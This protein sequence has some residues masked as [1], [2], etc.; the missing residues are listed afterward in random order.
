MYLLI[1]YIL[2]EVSKINES[3]AKFEFYETRVNGTCEKLM[4]TDEIRDGLRSNF[5]LVDRS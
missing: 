4:F 5:I 1:Q 3:R 2:R